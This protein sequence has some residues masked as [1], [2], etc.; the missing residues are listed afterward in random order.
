MENHMDILD[1]I[2]GDIGST[3]D[4]LVEARRLAWDLF[5]A[6]WTKDSNNNWHKSVRIFL[7]PNA[8]STYAR[9]TGQ[10]FWGRNRDFSSYFSINETDC[11]YLA[12]LGLHPIVCDPSGQWCEANHPSMEAV[13]AQI[14]KQ[15]GVDPQFLDFKELF[16]HGFE[17]DMMITDREYQTRLAASSEKPDTVVDYLGQHGRLGNKAL[18]G[19]TKSCKS[20]LAWV[21]FGIHIPS[22]CNV[23][24]ISDKITNG[25]LPAIVGRDVARARVIVSTADD[26]FGT[27]GG[28]CRNK[29]K[30]QLLEMVA[31]WD[32]ILVSLG[33][34]PPVRPDLRIKG[35]SD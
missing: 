7:L 35:I 25:V 34:E 22:S 15:K 30:E 12:P 29:S 23:G 4:P 18:N 27:Q 16:F 20:F 31:K 1:A 26:I 21:F 19:E 13:F 14:A 24:E 3:I 33:V 9:S 2:S 28:N 10:N 5:H 6:A 32:A 8:S 17:I 11:K